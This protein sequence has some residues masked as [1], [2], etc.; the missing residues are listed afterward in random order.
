METLTELKE[1]LMQ[2]DE[3]TLIDL[4]ELTSY[5]IVNRFYDVIETKSDYLSGEMNEITPYNSEELSWDN[6]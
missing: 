1:K 4:L 6:D 2:L 5:D 3:V